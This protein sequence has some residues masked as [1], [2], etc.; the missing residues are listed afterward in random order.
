MESLVVMSSNFW[1]NKKVLVTGHFGFLGSWLTKTLLSNEAKVVGLDIVK[2]RKMSVLSSSKKG[3]V[4]LKGDIANLKLINSVID[5]YKPQ[6]IFHLAAQAIVDKANKNPIRTFKSNIQGTWNML[7]AAR[8]RK[9]IESI[10]IASSDKAYG[11]HKVLPYKE[12]ASLKG[13]HPYDVSKSCT[14]LIAYTYYHTYGVPVNITR[15]G[16][17]FGP[18]DSNFSRIIPDAIKSIIKDKTLIIRSDGKFTRDYIYVDDIAKGY[19]LLAQKA[20]RLN[21][22]GEAFNF[23]C[24]NPINVLELV[25]KIYKLSGKKNNFKITNIAQYEIKHQYLDSKKAKKILGWKPKYTLSQGIKE[26]IKWYAKTIDKK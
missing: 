21:L 17:I 16:N 2:N 9:F 11:R 6:I 15:C 19:M 18:G 25:K 22:F 1:K 24:E 12:N 5:K 13:D 23:S 7:E 8:G 3:L 26:S 10:V 14:D 20:K 4:S